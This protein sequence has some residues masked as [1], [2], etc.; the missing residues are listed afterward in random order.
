[1]H[2]SCIQ[3][4]H[5]KRYNSFYLLT[6]V[7]LYIKKVIVTALTEALTIPNIQFNKIT[8]KALQTI[9]RVCWPR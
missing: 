8:L 4:T 5:K 1:M 7:F 3:H 2:D 9:I 6:Y